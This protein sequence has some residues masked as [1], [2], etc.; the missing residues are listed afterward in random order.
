MLIGVIQSRLCLG[1]KTHLHNM[2]LNQIPLNY[3]T[4][5][6]QFKSV[7]FLVNW[8]YIIK[9]DIIKV[10]FN[11]VNTPNTVTICLFAAVYIL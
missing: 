1:K 8:C 9:V 5:L 10:D 11:Y 2:T 4:D 7:I 3:I 6:L